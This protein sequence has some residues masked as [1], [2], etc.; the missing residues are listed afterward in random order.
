MKQIKKMTKPYFWI[1]FF[2]TNLSLLFSQTDG[3]L[4]NEVMSSNSATVEDEDGDYPDWLEIYNPDSESMSLKGYG[5]SDDRTEPGKWIL[6]DVT[7]GSGE[8][9]LV[10]ASGKN[11]TA[12]ILHTNFK[13]KFSGETVYLSL[14]RGGLCDSVAVDAQLP[15]VSYGR[16]PNG[17]DHWV[18]FDRPTPGQSNTPPAFYEQAPAVNTSPQGGF[19]SGAVGVTLSAPGPGQIRYTLDGSE[20]SATA[21]LYSAPLSLSRTTVMRA[22]CFES[23]KLPGAVVSRSFFIDERSTLPVISIATDPD[24][25]FDDDIGIY[26]VGNGTA[27]G[28]YPDNPIG[29]PANFWEDW[30]RPVHVEL[31]EADGRAGFSIDAGIKMAGKTTRVLPQKSFIIMMRSRYGTDVL[32]YPLFA[33]RPD[34][35]FTSLLLRNG[36]SDNTVNEGGTQLRDGLAARLIRTLSID[37]QAYRPAAVYLNGE[38]WGIYDVRDRVDEDYLYIHYGVDPEA[39]DILDDYHRLYPLVIEGSADHYNAM[40]DFLLEHSLA[41]ESNA[42]YIKTRM[43]VD[44]YLTYMS[45]QIFFANHDG[46]GHNCK[47]WRPQSADG[48]YRWILYDADHSFGFRLFIP[49]FHYAPDAYEDNTIA[50]YRETDGPSWPNPPEST[51]LFRKILENENFQNDFVNRLADLLNSAF[52]ADAA[53]PVLDDLATALETEMPRHLQRWGGDMNAWSENVDVVRTFLEKRAD[54]LTDHIINEFNL[55]GSVAVTLD[56]SPAAAGAVKISTLMPEI[57]PW[58]GWYFKNI[59]LPVTAHPAPGYRFDGWQGAE[60]A[61][62]TLLPSRNVSLVAR[63]S[64]E[65]NN[66]AAIVINEINYFSHPDFNPGDWIELYNPLAADMDVS[67]W[68]IKDDHDDHAFHVPPSTMIPA[69]GYLVLCRDSAAFHSLFPD[70][71]C[72]TGDLSFGLDH[73]ADSVRLY[74][75]DGRVK[76]AVGYSSMPPWPVQANGLGPTL[77]LRDPSLDNSRAENWTVSAGHGSPGQDNETALQVQQEKSAVP[78][79]CRLEQNYPNPFNHGTHITFS[80]AHK[81]RVTLTIHDMLGRRIKVLMDQDM[82]AGNYCSHWDGAD[83]SGRVCASGIYILNLQ[84]GEFREDRKMVLLR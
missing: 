1:F 10:F 18:Y 4:I 37:H 43:H 30:E 73:A 5:L 84:V 34:Q 53:C 68:I 67:G 21:K 12:A 77:A 45:A 52:A 58:Q 11:R 38:Y 19:Y 8:F 23:G 48:K 47:F 76:D 69:D 28:G 35:R 6:P 64:A 16:K 72:F 20:P 36:G 25:L 13:I 3:P 61:G 54:Y 33:D 26:V 7:L 74:A 75:A 31:F 27:L 56:V 62:S 70:I 32:T 14:P 41:D 66:P 40:I 50:Y 65:T 82:A 71:A 57:Y 55:A 79:S 44:N 29:P 46:P 22:R 9:K 81:A 78:G 63:F 51:F 2:Q 15:D 39:V 59:P 80:V 17:S 83:A 49:N 60:V 24:N 42:E